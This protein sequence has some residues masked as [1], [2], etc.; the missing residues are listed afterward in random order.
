[1]DKEWGVVMKNSNSKMAA[2]YVKCLSLDC[3]A[4]SVRNFAIWLTKQEK[5]QPL[6]PATIIVDKD[7]SVHIN[8]HNGKLEVVVSHQEQVIR[9]LRDKDGLHFEDFKQDV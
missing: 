3:C 5:K 8:E 1:M 4:D 9:I 7:C 2:Q 6:L